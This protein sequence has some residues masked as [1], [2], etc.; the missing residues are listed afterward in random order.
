VLAA[1]VARRVVAL[2]PDRFEEEFLSICR[3]KVR[4]PPDGLGLRAADCWSRFED[5]LTAPMPFYLVSSRELH[6]R[7]W[8]MSLA[9]AGLTVHDA[10]YLALAERWGAELWTLDDVL[11]GSA[12]STFAVVR[13]LRRHPFPY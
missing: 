10:L 2:A 9:I 3:K 1:I 5:V 4:P 6:D 7:A 13:D 11:G 8:Q 12:A